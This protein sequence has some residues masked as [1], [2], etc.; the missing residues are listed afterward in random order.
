MATGQCSVSTND[1]DEVAETLRAILSDVLALPRERVDG[2][3]DTTELF[4]ALPELDSMAV[5]TL[6]TAIEERLGTL[7][8]DDDV[9]AEDFATFG[10]LLA[11]ARRKVL[12]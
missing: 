7:I 12:I 5:A 4:G 11:F 1:F 9:E 8:E 3:D 10:S 6:L 2:F